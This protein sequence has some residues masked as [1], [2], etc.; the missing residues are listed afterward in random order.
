MGT[1]RIYNAVALG[2]ATDGGTAH[3]ERLPPTCSPQAL[4]QALTGSSD[5]V[6]AVLITGT[7]HHCLKVSDHHLTDAA[8]CVKGQ[9]STDAAITRTLRTPT[10]C[11]GVVAIASTNSLHTRRS[12]MGLRG[13]HPGLTL[14]GTA[15][16]KAGDGVGH[17]VGW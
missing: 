15:T 4:C 12:A 5:T 8:H 7:G 6:G 2:G 11:E 14:T 17:G 13:T 1:H 9:T 3:H 10:R 16:G